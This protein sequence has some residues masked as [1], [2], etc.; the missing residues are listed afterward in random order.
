[1]AGSE[2]NAWVLLLSG[3]AMANAAAWL[4]LRAG[5]PWW[6]AR[7]VPLALL[8][9]W[10]LVPTALDASFAAASQP[11]H[12]YVVGAAC[13]VVLGFPAWIADRLR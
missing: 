4:W 5:A 7:C 11:W 10:I 8:L 6:R 1:M 9:A 2:M 3:A 12:A 13:F